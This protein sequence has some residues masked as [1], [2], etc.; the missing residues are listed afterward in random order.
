MVPPSP[1]PFCPLVCTYATAKQEVKWLTLPLANRLSENPSPNSLLL[2][3]SLLPFLFPLSL[4][5]FGVIHL[6]CSLP[7]VEAIKRSP[8]IAWG[9]CS[10]HSELSQS[11]PHP[12]VGFF[13]WF[14]LVFN[15]HSL[16]LSHFEP[17]FCLIFPFSLF[18]RNTL[19]RPQCKTAPFRSVVGCA[20]K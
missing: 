5:W 14:I 17:F 9:D 16:F 7:T 20:F 6:V 8:Y 15:F 3:S 4:P 11:L 19:G 13:F 1:P 18:P 12:V 2:G 10:M